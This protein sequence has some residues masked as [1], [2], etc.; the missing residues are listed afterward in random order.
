MIRRLGI[1]AM[2]ALS[3]CC[4]RG[5]PTAAKVVL[6]DGMTWWGPT[7]AVADARA[8]WYLDPAWRVPQNIHALGY[9]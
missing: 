9:R 6:P 4:H 3:G 8:R 7:Q 5:S 2:L 1:V